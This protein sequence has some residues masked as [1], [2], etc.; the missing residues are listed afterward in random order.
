MGDFHG[1]LQPT[2]KYGDPAAIG[3][4]FI[5]N[6]LING[7]A[8]TS[9]PIKV[10]SNEEIEKARAELASRSDEET[11]RQEMK[12]TL[13]SVCRELLLLVRES[14]RTGRPEE[15][16]EFWLEHLHEF[17]SML[18]TILKFSRRLGRPRKPR[19]PEE[20]LFVALAARFPDAAEELHFL[21]SAFDSASRQASA[22]GPV[23]EDKRQEDLQIVA[24]F[25][26]WG[27]H[28]NICLLTLNLD[29]SGLVKLNDALR[30][31]VFATARHAAL[32]FNHATM[33][34][35][36]LRRTEDAEESGEVERVDF[37]DDLEHA[38]MVIRGL[39][40]GAT[41]G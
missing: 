37:D 21:M 41:G 6:C 28:F 13:K 34:A 7:N 40:G 31:E 4:S 9:G 35:A 22:F 8:L 1:K 20:E 25:S 17:D 24:R 30:D 2:P 15:W 12:A 26:F 38:E 14:V 23:P 16:S 11:L 3:G 10:V 33:S 5:V 39:E 32:E 36:R 27:A 18:A 29:A 19:E